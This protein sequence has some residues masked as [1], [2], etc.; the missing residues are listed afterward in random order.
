MIDYHCSS[1][2]I[3]TLRF[4]ARAVN[5]FSRMFQRALGEALARLESQAPL[6]GVIVAF[7]NVAPAAEH[8][9]DH[10]IALT[11]AQA[12]DC[13]A[14]LASYHALLRRLETLGRPVLATL[15]G[16]IHCHALGLALACHARLALDGTTLSLPQVA[17]GLTPSGGA[18]VRMVRGIGLRAA[19]PLLVEG[20]AL[21]AAAA[22]QA[23]LLQGVA[24]DAAQLERQVHA[25]IAA[26]PAP[27]QP[28]DDK[29]Y[30]MPG[31]APGAPQL[32]ALL[33]TAPAMLRAQTG[34]HY[35]APEA[36]LCAMV[37][38]AQVDFASALLI[39]DRYFCH[40]ASGAVAKNLMRLYQQRLAAAE[41]H[42][43][44]CAALRA[45]YRDEAGRLAREGV[46]TALIENAAR[47]AGLGAPP[48]PEP[49]QPQHP[50]GRPGGLGAPPQQ[51]PEPEQPQHPQGRPG[52][53][54]SF[55]DARDRLLYAQCAAALAVV[56]G[57][58]AGAPTPAQA[59][60]MSVDLCGFPA[61][62]GG[63]VAF[64]AHVGAD[65]YAAR[66]AVLAERYGNRFAPRQAPL[67]FMQ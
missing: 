35:P 41:A 48:Q 3:V 59:D 13:M 43:G 4:Q 29:H 5:P 30:R 62:T 55:A 45:S 33:Q 46:T 58:Q 53:P 50:Q 56:G 63:A 16:H 11:P 38:G 61:F 24:G 15:D 20:Q 14:T 37:E 12:G 39:E 25:A 8:E 17:L 49:G 6:A 40:V 26:M 18:L 32:Q 2:H 57:G 19:L 34:G 1:A 64:V 65:A 54:V 28:W 36:T 27:A 7:D 60:L 67:Q 51:Q 22:L 44:L 10:L 66:A 23:G 21:D 31:G 52:A 47:A 9:L 42:P